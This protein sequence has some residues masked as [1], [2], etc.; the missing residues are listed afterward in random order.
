ML[1]LPMLA[2]HRSFALLALLVT[3][4]AVPAL[5]Q[6]GAPPY[7]AACEA[8]KVSKTDSE[9]AHQVFLS[10]KQFLDES[11]YD[12]AIQYFR[13]A[14]ALDCSVHEILP[15][16]ATAYERKG[17]RAEAIRALE[18]YLK[19]SPNA[20]DKER[21]ERRIKN[22]KDQLPA[23]A[24]T[25]APPTA[26]TTAPTATTTTTATPT[27]TTTAPPTTTATTPPPSGGRSAVPLIVAGIGGAALATGV[28]LLIIGNGKVSDAESRC[29][30]D[31]P[32]GR[33]CRNVEAV[34]DGNSGRSLMTVGGVVGG[35]GLAAVIGGLVWYFVQPANR[36]GW[37]TPQFGP[38]YAGLSGS[39]TF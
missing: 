22:L 13:D 27:A 9:R 24:T 4:A 11:N 26:S 5:A 15:I 33:N 25:T 23:T 14:Y 39:G 32:G 34:A 21:V 36:V 2:R 7:P 28:V 10:G 17:D 37:L 16:I 38:G 1:V 29:D 31:T 18:E 20:P 19:R 35:V 12:K 6:T 3:A 30:P 8:S